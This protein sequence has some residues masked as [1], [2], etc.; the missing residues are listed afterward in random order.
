MT[1]DK[2]VFVRTPEEGKRGSD[3]WFWPEIGGG[4]EDIFDF[5][6]HVL[7]KTGKLTLEQARD[8]TAKIAER[9]A[10]L[11]AEM[12]AEAAVAKGYD[13]D[14]PRV[15]AGNPEGGQWT[16]DAAPAGGNGGTGKPAPVDTQRAAVT[17][18]EKNKGD[19]RWAMD[20]LGV[21][22]DEIKQMF[23]LP[24]YE[25]RIEVMTGQSFSNPRNH[26][27]AFDVGVQ[28]FDGETPVGE[29]L[30]VFR[31][32]GD[33]QICYNEEFNLK[34]EF[35]DHDL[36]RSLYERQIEVL[37]HDTEVDKVR[38][39]AN[40]TA[41][42]YA[43]AKLGFQYNTPGQQEHVNSRFRR[44]SRQHGI[45]LD[46]SG[47]WPTF[48]T[49]QDVATF[50]LP[51]VKIKHTDIRCNGVKPGDYDIGKAFMLDDQGHGAWSAV[52]WLRKD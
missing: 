29:A 18:Q 33:V 46:E 15:P 50:R 35:Q 2:L 28:W 38:L 25:A 20:A 4:D 41:G 13:P 31:D 11:D 39:F 1:M 51:G 26:P 34:P 9:Q 22:E 44:W 36:A 40:V 47:G 42:R 32:E 5:P 8:L 43:W 17:Y 7:Y 19:C 21:S 45:D 3:A 12:A 27:P 48:K 24:G 37:A 52:L 14:Q 6:I 10:L 16:D 23:A 49:P 30:R